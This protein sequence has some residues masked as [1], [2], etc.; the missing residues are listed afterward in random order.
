MKRAGNLCPVME[1]PRTAALAIL[2]GTQHKHH[3]KEVQH[4]FL[5]A[6]RRT[7]DLDKVDREAKALAESVHTWEPSPLKVKYLH[8]P[9]HKDRELAIP[10]LPDHLHGW[11]LILTI[12]T[13]LMRGMHPF[14][15]G[16]VPG[17]GIEYGRKAVESWVQHDGRS[18]WFVK[19]DLIQ[20][21][22]NV[23]TD[24]LKAKFRTRI[25]NPEILRLIDLHIDMAQH[26]VDVN[27][28]LL[29]PIPGLPIGT[30]PAPWFA[31]FYLQDFDHYVTEQLYKTRRGKRQ[32]LVRH[33]LRNI[34]DILLI[35]SSQRDLEK[36][37]R[38]VIEYLTS[39]G[40]RIHDNW[41]IRRI[42]EMEEQDGEYRLTPGTCPVDILG[43]KFYR[44]ETTVRGKIYLRTMQTARK[45][46]KDLDR[47]FLML[48]DA[49][50]L[51][52]R[53]GWFSHA[54]SKTFMRQ[55]NGMIPLKFIKG[56]ISYAG[57]N[58]IVGTTAVLYCGPGKRLGSYKILHGHSGGP[59]R[60]QHGVYG[61]HVGSGD[62]VAGKPR[63]QD[64][65]KH[66]GLDDI[67]PGQSVQ[68]SLF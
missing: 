17:R 12:Q 31:N 22:R 33:Y 64:H 67:G 52:S 16:S 66:G 13:V 20:F 34:D 56:A 7:V 28:N 65:R 18:N 35:G 50:S 42:G 25:K 14:C 39:L 57:K 1:D 55:I 47:G 61:H 68:L 53:I 5:A 49:E 24:R 8:E 40:L 2:G 38:A 37:V 46:R 58:G 60:G 10:E 48:H 29:D 32:N 51:I 15:V 4:R 9:G 44:A 63:V 6:D 54:D 27:G 19:L 36:A 43:Y 62:A 30:Y 23:D 11:I 59:E 26:A 41:E 45:I 3:L 21:Y